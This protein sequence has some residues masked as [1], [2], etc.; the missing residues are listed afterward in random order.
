MSK[1]TE[2]EL[3]AAFAAKATEA[4]QAHDVLRAVR[5]AEQSAH[6]RRNRLRWLVPA[7]AAAAAVAVAVPLVISG[8]GASKKSADVNVN[9]RAAS[10]GGTHAPASSPRVPGATH[11]QSAKGAEAK[12]APSQPRLAPNSLC[13]P[14]D[15]TA[16]LTVA[17]ATNATLTLTARTQACSVLRVPSLRWDS[18]LARPD[19]PLVPDSASASLPSGGSGRLAGGATATALV[20]GN[21]LCSSA[22]PRVVQVNWGAGDV[23]VSLTGATAG[24]CVPGEKPL[25]LRISAFSGL[26]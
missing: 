25:D 1:R 7:V 23:T 18:A 2:D 15:V 24:K 16:T 6:S 3:R 22:V 20:H 26:D 10:A 17:D 5:Q 4:P 19:T 13:Q 21:A 9:Q 12:P 8:N 11:D 14:Q